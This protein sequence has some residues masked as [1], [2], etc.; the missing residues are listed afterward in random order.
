MGLVGMPPN[1]DGETWV[2]PNRPRSARVHEE[3]RQRSAHRVHSARSQRSSKRGDAETVR[4]PEVVQAQVVSASEGEREQKSKWWRAGKTAKIQ[5]A[6]SRGVRVEEA[7]GK[8]PKG[9]RKDMVQVFIGDHQRELEDYFRSGMLQATLPL[10]ASRIRKALG[11]RAGA[12]RL[13]WLLCLC[14]LALGVLATY[15]NFR[16]NA[17]EREMAELTAAGDGTGP[18]AAADAADGPREILYTTNVRLSRGVVP[19]ERFARVCRCVSR[20]A[21]ALPTHIVRFE[22]LVQHIYGGANAA[23]TGRSQLVTGISLYDV[24]GAGYCDAY[25]EGAGGDDAADEDPRAENHAC[26][27]QLGARYGASAKLLWQY[28][29]LRRGEGTDDAV[30]FRLP[31]E[32]GIRLE[33]GRAYDFVAQVDYNMGYFFGESG[34]TAH[35]HLGSQEGG[36]TAQPLSIPRKHAQPSVPDKPVCVRAI[37]SWAAFS[38]RCLGSQPV[39]VRYRHSTC[40]WRLRCG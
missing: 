20:P 15:L 33:Q 26:D 1:V 6:M 25:G 11:M 10:T 40:A 3:Q 24:S 28:S 23:A 7:G 13:L 32:A 19:Y 35:G 30:N 9:V 8:K 29:P 16:L 37:H 2:Q 18:G 38:D 34:N 12:R 39:P 22:A 36:G 4:V 14:V 17:S 27:D 21:R 5:E 31:A